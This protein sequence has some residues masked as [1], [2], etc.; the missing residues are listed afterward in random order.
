VPAATRDERRAAASK[1]SLARL[2]GLDEDGRRLITEAARARLRERDL[3][4]VDP[5]RQLDDDER[6][7]QM[8]LYRRGR[9]AEVALASARARRRKAADR[10]YH[11]T[12]ALLQ[13]AGFELDDVV[14]LGELAAGYLSE[15]A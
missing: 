1:A 7:R 15:A 3:D 2:A 8:T 4:A 6:E 11:D 10:S 9:M 5:E 13:A 12:L 14:E